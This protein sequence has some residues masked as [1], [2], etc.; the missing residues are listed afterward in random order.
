MN[1]TSTAT[2]LPRSI[3]DKINT[4]REKAEKYLAE[5]GMSPVLPNGDSRFVEIG[6]FA[7]VFMAF[8]LG[9][10]TRYRTLRASLLASPGMGGE[11]C[12]YWLGQEEKDGYA[13]VRI[14]KMLFVMAYGKSIPKGYALD[15]VCHRPDEC[16]AKT[17]CPHR[18]CIDPTHVM[19]ATTSE[20]NYRSSQAGLKDECGKGH[21]IVG[22]N[23]RLT[24]HGTPAKFSRCVA[25]YDHHREEV[26]SGTYEP[27][28]RNGKG[29]VCHAGHRKNGQDRCPECNRER[30]RA[31]Y[32]PR[33]NGT[34][35][36]KELL[37]I[38]ELH[39]EDLGLA[40]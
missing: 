28:R 33:K 38:V 2:P 29:D 7:S 16:D 13:P 37:Q 27:K 31:R 15:H 17:K 1:N 11:E 39:R 26:K 20:N 14:R 12:T 21:E 9:L 32:V 25:C 22:D 3:S 30:E 40:V 10:S 8:F 34:K 19:L 4:H 36:T 18:K 5:K 6:F 35:S 23:L 24:K